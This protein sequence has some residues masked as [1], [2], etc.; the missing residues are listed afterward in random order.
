MQLKLWRKKKGF[1]QSDLAEQI[2][3]TEPLLSYFEQGK[4]LPTRE[5][6]MLLETVMDLSR[7]DLYT[8][9]ELTLHDNKKRPRKDYKHYHVHIKLPKMFKKVLNQVNFKAAGY[10]D[11]NDW[12]L[13]KVKQFMAQLK[14]IENAE[15]FKRF[16][17]AR[18][19]EKASSLRPDEPSYTEFP[20]Q[21]KTAPIIILEAEGKDNRT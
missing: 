9:D 8:A 20:E 6:L 21:R 11:M 19:K 3:V 14:I 15:Y 13:Y 4:A 16:Y 1:R 12:F 2:Q 18:Q 10:K 7:Y 5:T 17:E